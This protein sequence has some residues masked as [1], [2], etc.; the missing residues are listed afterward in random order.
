[1]VRGV[2]GAVVGASDER[3]TLP[4][5][6]L[7]ERLVLPVDGVG[8]ACGT[9]GSE[10]PGEDVPGSAAG[11]RPTPRIEPV[12]VTDLVLDVSMPAGPCSI[13]P[14]IL[15]PG[16]RVVLPAAAVL[17]TSAVL[18]LA[19]ELLLPIL[20]PFWRA[21]DVDIPGCRSTVAVRCGVRAV[22]VRPSVVIV[23]GRL[24]RLVLGIHTLL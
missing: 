13:L 11:M 23:R 14:L 18:R 2:A 4:I 5:V 17:P 21:P 6:L 3:R 15:A 22:L 8:L 10:L 24:P 12:E 16:C 9:V 20:A 7:D 19:T 1:V